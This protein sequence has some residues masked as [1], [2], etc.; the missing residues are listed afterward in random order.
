[1]ENKITNRNYYEALITLGTEGRLA[2]TNAEDEVVEI[3]AEELVTWAEKNIAQLDKR[4]ETARV[5]TE[6][7]KAESDELT[8]VVYDAVSDEFETI[9]DIAARVDVEDISVSKVQARLA[10]LLAAE[11]V[12]KDTVKV[13]G[14]KSP[15]V[16]YKRA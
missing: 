12:V 13:E 15:R 14:S 16:A 4:N 2:F 6:K 11:R 5:R 10:K 8:E 7:K 3:S 1:M 9:A